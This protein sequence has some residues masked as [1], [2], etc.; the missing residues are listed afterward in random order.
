MDITP[1]LD[2]R[3]APYGVLDRLA[4]HRDRPRFY[5]RNSDKSWRA[6]TWGEHA[7]DLR[8]VAR[9]LIDAGVAPGDRVAVFAANSVA[10]AASAIGIQA[11]GGSRVR[12]ARA[13][14]RQARAVAVGSD[15]D[16]RR[17]VARR[18]RSGRRR[19]AAALDRSRSA[20]V[21]ALHERHQRAAER[22]AAHAP[23]HRRERGRLAS[24]QRNI[25]RRGL[26]RS[27]VAPDEPHLR[28]R[29]AV[30]R[31]HARLG[32]VAR[33][34]A[35]RARAVARRRAARLLLGARVLGEGGARGR[36]A[37]LGPVVACASACRAARGSRSRSR[38]SCIARAC[39]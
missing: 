36:V 38:R 26:P 24:L 30:P 28:A 4:T 18:E 9:W 21:D 25:D 33:L 3:P 10:W 32:V 8:A 13:R 23:Q 15:G 17:V 12:A 37:R 31:Q 27:A 1:F 35:R 22:R 34:A 5:V 11:A 7:R 6:V 16:R 14:R 29:R 19:R 20:G 2:L 39:S